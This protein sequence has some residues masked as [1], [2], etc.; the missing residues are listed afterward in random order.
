[1][2]QEYRETTITVFGKTQVIRTERTTTIKAM[3][4][5]HTRAV[6][7]ALKEAYAAVP[8]E[9]KKAAKA[10]MQKKADKLEPRNHILNWTPEDRANY[11]KAAALR[12]AIVLVGKHK[13]EP[14]K[15]SYVD[16]R[17]IP[18]RYT[19]TIPDSVKE[20]HEYIQDA[21]V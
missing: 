2:S 21:L 17:P 14:A 1:M 10:K 12:D 16:P 7:N 3:E 18:V 20:Y 5:L 6:R 11:Y 13:F 15:S 9:T 4:T 8:D 19:D